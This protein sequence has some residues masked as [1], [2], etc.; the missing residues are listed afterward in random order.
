MKKDEIEPRLPDNPAPGLTEILFDAGPILQGGMGA[1]PLTATELRA[2]Q[3][4]TG[5]RLTP[6]EFR[7]LRTLSSAYLSELQ[8][9]SD[10]SRPPPFGDLQRNPN[11]SRAIDEALG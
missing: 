1:S 5:T 3:Q 10:P 4:G 6:W 9:A 2:W 11:L 7:T 8:Q